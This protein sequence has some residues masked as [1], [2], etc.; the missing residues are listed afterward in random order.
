MVVGGFQQFSTVACWNAL[1]FPL[2][3]RN[4][5]C[6]ISLIGVIAG[7]KEHLKSP[8]IFHRRL[9]RLVRME[10]AAD[11]VDMDEDPPKVELSDEDRPQQQGVHVEFM[12][13]RE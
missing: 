7:D 12:N 2:V 13:F 11:D 10:E 6:H 5:V 8:N 1:Y 9:S 3:T 4:L